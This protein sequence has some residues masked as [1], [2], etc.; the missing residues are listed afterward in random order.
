MSD[1]FFYIKNGIVLGYRGYDTAIEI[2]EG[3]VKI[4]DNAFQNHPIIEQVTIPEGVKRIGFYAFRGCRKLRGIE[5]PE[6][7]KKIDRHAFDGCTGLQTVIYHGVRF[8]AEKANL[9]EV[10]KLIDTKDFSVNEGWTTEVKYNVLWG[11][12]SRNPE[13]K[14]VLGA[15]RKNFVKMFRYLIDESDTETAGKVLNESKLVN[16]RNLESIT[17]YAEEKQNEEIQAILKA[18]QEKNT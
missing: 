4:G 3:T 14:E 9:E 6:S 17:K 10:F 16:K 12:F 15:I 7:V 5:I 1:R 8:K 13:D 11:M 18:Y 2:P